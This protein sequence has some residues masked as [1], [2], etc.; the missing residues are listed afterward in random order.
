LYSADNSV[1]KIMSHDVI[2]GDINTAL[3]DPTSMAVSESFARRYFGDRNPIG[4]DIY[5]DIS[6]YRI[7]LV[8]ADLRD[9][10]HLKYDALMSYNRIAQPQGTERREALWNIN[11]YTYLLMR[12]GYDPGDFNTISTSFFENNMADMARQMNINGTV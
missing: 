11:A 10:S 8:F 1:L 4:E 12:E 9:N 3:V 7:D 6:N 2:Y 5:T